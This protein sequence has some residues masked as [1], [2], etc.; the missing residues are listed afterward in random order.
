MLAVHRNAKG[1]QAIQQRANWAG[2]GLFVAINGH[3]AVGK[4]RQRRQKT[5]D[6][7]S[8]TAVDGGGLQRGRFYGDGLW[9]LSDT[10]A[11]RAQSLRH[12]LGIARVQRPQNRRGA[13]S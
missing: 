12:Q 8:Q 13:I 3:R 1:T 10:H 7:S 9:R 2:P 11:H 6:R 4:R 5:H